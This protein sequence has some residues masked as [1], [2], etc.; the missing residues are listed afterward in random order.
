MTVYQHRDSIVAASGSTSTTTLKVLGGL[1]RQ[2]LVTAN[3]STTVFRANLVDENSVTVESWG[4]ST[5]QL[6]EDAL[7]LPI[8]GSYKLN[9]TNISPNDTFTVLMSVQE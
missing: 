9:L 7:A 5:G 8:A 3:T 6:R 1:L 2:V 4:W